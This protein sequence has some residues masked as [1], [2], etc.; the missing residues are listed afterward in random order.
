[1]KNS[2]LLGGGGGYIRALYIAEKMSVIA[3][4]HLLNSFGTYVIL[5][6]ICG[7]VMLSRCVIWVRTIY[8]SHKSGTHIL[9]VVSAFKHKTIVSCVVLRINMNVGVIKHYNNN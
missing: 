5:S 7:D 3:S 8:N 6:N 9:N 1:M 4:P 2:V